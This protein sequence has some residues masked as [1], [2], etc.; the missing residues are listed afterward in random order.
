MDNS[1]EPEKPREKPSVAIF[2]NREA[3]VRELIDLTRAYIAKDLS[4]E[5]NDITADVAFENGAMVPRFGIDGDKI[6]GFWSP[7]LVRETMAKAYSEAQ[8]IMNPRFAVVNSRRSD[9]YAD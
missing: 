2:L 7:E 9:Y 6:E 4:L 1:I 8:K 5:I 3:L